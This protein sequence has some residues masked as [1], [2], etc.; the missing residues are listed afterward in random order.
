MG[1]SG[2]GRAS[3][4]WSAPVSQEQFNGFVDEF[5]SYTRDAREWMG[6][7]NRQLSD[8]QT[9]MAVLRNDSATY[10]K[11]ADEASSKIRLLTIAES[12]RTDREKRE[13]T[14]ALP[15]LP[16]KQTFT[17]LLKDKF[18]SALAMVVVAVC[19]A[20]GWTLLRSYVAEH[21]NVP[22]EEAPVPAKHDRD[23]REPV[24]WQSAHGVAIPAGIPAN[25]PIPAP[26]P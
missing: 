13:E 26:K 9:T 11:H 7:V 15:A 24:D 18:L 20:T 12:V 3:G 19:M 22:G 17:D 14:V 4:E 6:T 10:L 21:P 5:R 2:T 16:P 8:G 1:G 25:A 23:H